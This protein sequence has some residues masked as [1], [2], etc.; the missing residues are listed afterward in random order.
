[1]KLIIG[2]GNPG[3]EYDLT[4]HNFGY[5]VLDNLAITL[6]ASAFK[7]NKKIMAGCMVVR[8]TGDVRYIIPIMG[9]RVCGNCSG[10][11]GHRWAVSAKR[12]CHGAIAL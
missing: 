2:L 3:R 7:V 1:M 5:A 9:I 10:R 8:S 4:R 6:S 11:I 12:H